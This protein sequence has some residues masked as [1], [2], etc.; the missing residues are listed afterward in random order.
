ML[1]GPQ[2]LGQAQE[3]DLQRTEGYASA[4]REVSYDKGKEPIVQ[5]LYSTRIS[6]LITD[7]E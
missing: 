2:Q 1:L 6:Y 3:G 4:L 7:R 5:F